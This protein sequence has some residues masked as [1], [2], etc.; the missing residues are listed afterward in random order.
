[1][2]PKKPLLV[3]GG[4][5]L[6][7]VATYAVAFHTATPAA[8]LAYWCYSSDRDPEW[9]ENVCYYAFYPAYKFHQKVIGGPRHNWDREYVSPEALA[10]P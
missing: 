3:L 10:Q 1:M 7:Y 9:V 6:V 2:K 4:F 5:L 8:N